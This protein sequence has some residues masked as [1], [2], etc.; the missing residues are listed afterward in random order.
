MGGRNGVAFA[1]VSLSCAQC[2]QLRL[3][4]SIDYFE[5]SKFISHDVLRRSLSLTSVMLSPL[6]RAFWR[7]LEDRL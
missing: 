6:P 3:E 7:L 5:R 4:T 2:V 1:G